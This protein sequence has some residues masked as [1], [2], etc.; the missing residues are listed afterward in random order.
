MTAPNVRTLLN[1]PM[2]DGEVSPKVTWPALVLLG[3]GILLVLLSFVLDG[4]GVDLLDLG[5]TLIVAS[6]LAGGVGYSA[7][8]GRVKAP[9]LAEGG[10]TIGRVGPGEPFPGG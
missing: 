7:K 8:V 6:G 4:L 9:A 2:A 5:I 1:P 3:L 10:T